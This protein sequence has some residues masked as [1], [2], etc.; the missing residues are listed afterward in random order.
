MVVTPSG[1]LKRETITPNPP[2]EKYL[3]ISAAELAML[4]NNDDLAFFNQGLVNNNPNNP[5]NFN[6]LKNINLPHGA[7]IINI[8]YYCYDVS[9]TSDFLIFFKRTEDSV[10]ITPPYYSSNL[11]NTLTPYPGQNVI[12]NENY[13][14]YLVIKA[15]PN[16][17][18]NESTYMYTLSLKKIVITYTE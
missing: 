8:K 11:N 7:T 6:V 18:T 5:T 16:I 14:Y 2:Q 1:I 10:E 12:D 17:P 9:P 15:S 13:S 4:A 3:S